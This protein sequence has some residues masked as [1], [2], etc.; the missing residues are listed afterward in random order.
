MA[1]IGLECLRP[2]F[3]S[4]SPKG[5]ISK[6]LQI[7]FYLPS[8]VY[9]TGTYIQMNCVHICTLI[10]SCFHPTSNL[11]STEQIHNKK[12]AQWVESM[13]AGWRACTPGGEHV[14]W[15]V[16]MHTVWR[17]HTLGGEHVHW[18]ESMYTGWRACTLGGEHAHWVMSMHAGWQACLINTSSRHPQGT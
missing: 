11:R 5:N 9:C 15:V 8:I 6:S 13:H 7:L 18:V 2:C 14:H 16:S 10:Y 3:L 4:R 12:H 1:F 17:A